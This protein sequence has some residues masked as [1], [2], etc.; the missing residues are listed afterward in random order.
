MGVRD[1]TWHPETPPQL[2]PRKPWLPDSPGIWRGVRSAPSNILPSV[3]SE[4]ALTLSRTRTA[5]LQMLPVLQPAAA[6][7][8]STEHFELALQQ[9]RCRSTARSLGSPKFNRSPR[10]LRSSQARSLVTVFGW[11]LLRA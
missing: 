2:P 10:C 1:P 3:P 11:A 6:L 5:R 4:N 9:T 8:H 7:T